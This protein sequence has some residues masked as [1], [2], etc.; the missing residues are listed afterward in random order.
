MTRLTRITGSTA[1]LAIVLAGVL[2]GCA[3]D[4]PTVQLPPKTTSPGLRTVIPSAVP[5]AAAT[6]SPAY[7]STTASAGAGAGTGG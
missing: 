4:N 1:G 3:G 2:G 5:T 6:V 7:P